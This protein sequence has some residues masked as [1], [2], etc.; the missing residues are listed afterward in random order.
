[1]G[2]LRC[3]NPYVFLVGCLRSG[4]TL[5][6][7][8]VDAHPEIAVI[9]ETQ[10]VPRWY[11]RRVGLTEEGI[12]TP[13]LVAR[14]VEHRRFHRL[15]LDAERVTEL[16]RD[17]EPKHYAH[18]VTELF[19]LHGQVKGKTL[20]G[21]KSPGYVR[22]LPT[23]HLLWPRTK[24]VHLI[25]DGRDVTLSVLDWKKRE[26]TAGRFP[27][28]HEDPVSTTALWWEW[29]VRLGREAAASLGPERYYE[30]S[31]EALVADPERECERLCTFLG[32]TYD[33]AMLR[34]HEGR[35]RPK[36]GRSA[37][38]A[39]LPVTRDLRSWR[40]QMATG[41]VERYEAV[42]GALLD[43][44]GYARAVPVIDREQLAR[45]ARLRNMFIDDV[46]ARRRRVPAAWRKE[47]A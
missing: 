7:R 4:T 21:E 14:L 39:W 27:T 11:E 35:T 46:C 29:H 32:V 34:F 37:K 44:L 19:D 41:D 9:H 47:A 22:H 13:E 40:Q 25:R 17:G 3:V 16:I 33:D 18:F 45:A 6:Q 43:E 1:M 12:V 38:A 15:Q 2:E 28:W 20:V 26:G 5:L 24:V 23:L 8:V 10:W 30:L 36:P 31:Y 42:A